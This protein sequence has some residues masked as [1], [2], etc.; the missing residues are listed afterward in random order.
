MKYFT[1][2][3]LLSLPFIAQAQNTPT[4]AQNYIEVTGTAEKTVIPDEI[5][6]SITLHERYNGKNK[7]TIEK[8]EKKLK[9]ALLKEGFKLDDLSVSDAQGAYVKVKWTKKDVI[10]QKELLMQVSTASEV[11]QIFTIL[12]DLDLEDARIA[13]VDHSEMDAFKKE[14]KIEAIKTAKDKATYL[15]SA[16]GE[17]PGK[18]MVIYEND[19]Y[20]RP[21]T[22]NVMMAQEEGLFSESSKGKMD[23]LSIQ[24]EKITIRASIYVK[25]AIQ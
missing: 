17:K 25:Y 4:E 9:E 10:N 7:V 5:Y 18:P 12:D 8:Q 6:I 19:H 1:F 21:N 22:R 16:I 15:L 23:D 2:L 11:A 20:Y 3:L 13:R 24:F 14:V